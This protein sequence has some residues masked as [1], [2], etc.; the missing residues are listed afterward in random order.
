MAA[1]SRASPERV[2]AGEDPVAGHQAGPSFPLASSSPTPG[3]ESARR[4]SEH[5]S[6]QLD[7]VAGSWKGFG[8][9]A[10]ARPLTVFLPRPPTCLPTQLV[11]QGP[12][13]SPRRF[14][15]PFGWPP[16]CVERAHHQGPD[17]PGSSGS[18]T[19]KAPTVNQRHPTHFLPQICTAC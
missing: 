19:S 9:P 1:A 2:P 16:S 13:H 6:L 8:A 18:R 17:H 12:L 10:P 11:G 3:C 5:Q 15:R 7:F 14:S 4:N